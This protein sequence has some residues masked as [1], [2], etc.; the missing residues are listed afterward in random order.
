MGMNVLVIQ[1]SS[2]TYSL[3]YAPQKGSDGW[4]FTRKK[5][6]SSCFS[7]EHG[8]YYEIRANRRIKIKLVKESE[9]HFPLTVYDIDANWKIG[10]FDDFKSLRKELNMYLVDT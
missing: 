2:S 4:Y 10:E 9:E 8:D 7:F 1:S 3:V 5:I 6:C